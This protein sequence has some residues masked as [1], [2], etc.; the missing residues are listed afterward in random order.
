MNVADW[1]VLAETL[2]SQIILFNR[3]RVGEASKF[4]LTS[5]GSRN[6][7]LPNEDVVKSLTKLEQQLCNELTRLEIR[8]KKGKKVPVL[9]TKDMV[10]SMDM[11]NE[12]RSKV[13]IDK[14]NPYVFARV[15]ALT[16]IRGSDCLRNFS[17]T[18]GAKDPRNLTLTKLR[19]QVATLSQIMNLKNNEIPGT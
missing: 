18:C 9:L 6:A 8:G 12:S 17:K 13:G 5:Y 16:H 14:D 2:L 7:K 15:G 1:K 11:L 3:R 10:E 19:K 4:L